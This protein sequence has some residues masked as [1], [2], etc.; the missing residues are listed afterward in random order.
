MAIVDCLSKWTIRSVGRNMD[1]LPLSVKNLKLFDNGSM[2]EFDI[3]G[4]VA[5]KKYKKY[6]VAYVQKY[7]TCYTGTNL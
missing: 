2:D 7:I 1:F 3:G 4:H 5:P 6:T